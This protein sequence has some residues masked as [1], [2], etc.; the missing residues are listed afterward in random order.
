MNQN[1]KILTV[2]IVLVVIVAIYLSING[3]KPTPQN[4]PVSQNGELTIQANPTNVNNNDSADNGNE[5][6]S[7]I[8][9]EE[10]GSYEAYS[11]EKVVLASDNHDVVLFFRANWCPTCRAV[12][13]DIR[14]NLNKIPTNVTILDVDYDNSS[15][16]KRKYNV[17]YQHTFVQV[18]KD[19]NLIKKWSGSPT[20][21]SLIVEIS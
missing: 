6:A 21:S 10:S 5:N 18:D 19:G 2:A 9:V 7:N 16:L 12:D 13:S 1:A 17:T 4:N 3:K 14:A 20:L 8:T 15:E 11:P